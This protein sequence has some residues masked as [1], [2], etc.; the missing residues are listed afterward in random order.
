MLSETNHRN[1]GSVSTTTTM[2]LVM[3][4]H[5]CWKSTKETRHPTRWQRPVCCSLH[6][7]LHPRR[8]LHSQQSATAL[9]I[10]SPSSVVNSFPSTSVVHCRMTTP[11]DYRPLTE[12]MG[13]CMHWLGN[14]VNK[15]LI[16][17]YIIGDQTRAE[18]YR[19][20]DPN[21]IDAPLLILIW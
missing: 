19:W 12:E 4:V 5:K 7:P 15:Q 2:T 14:I 17:C 3:R 10:Q 1:V 21:G 9:H 6:H 18:C 16:L 8:S 11:N 20:W 13:N